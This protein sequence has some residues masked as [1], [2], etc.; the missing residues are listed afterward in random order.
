M[1]FQAKMRKL[2]AQLKEKKEKEKINEA[3]KG[4]ADAM[5]VDPTETLGSY[6]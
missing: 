2:G 4:L 6:R 3:N 5:D 1:E